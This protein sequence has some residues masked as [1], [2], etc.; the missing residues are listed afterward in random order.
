MKAVTNATDLPPWTAEY[1]YIVIGGGTAGC[2]LAATLSANYSVLV[3]ERGGDPETYQDLLRAENFEALMADE[4]DGEGP[5]ERF[6]S[7]D[8]V[9]NARGRVLG[10][11]SMINMGFYSR[12][13]KEFY[14]RSGVE[15]EMGSVEEAYEWVE[16]SVVHRSAEMLEWQNSVK[17]ALLEAGVGP[18]N[19]FSLDHK[20]GTKHSGSIFDDFGG[21][22]GAAELLNRADLRNLRVAV[23]ATVERILF[24][25][26]FFDLIIKS[27]LCGK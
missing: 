13:E 11:S 17:E 26:M 14:E 6:R 25:G 19:G 7:E 12:A 21:R 24:S 15:W 27:N 22:H 18:Y 8:G 1:D 3:L 23:R 9:E 16:E 2:P 20:L 4:D 10:G 5:V